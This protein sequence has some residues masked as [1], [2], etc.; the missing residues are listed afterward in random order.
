MP[1]IYIYRVYPNRSIQHLP[2]S[3]KKVQVRARCMDRIISP[4]GHTWHAF[5]LNGS[6]ASEEFMTYRVVPDLFNFR[7]LPSVTSSAV[8]ARCGVREASQTSSERGP[9][10]RTGANKAAARRPSPCGRSAQQPADVVT[11]RAQHRMQSV[12]LCTLQVTAVHPV[13]FLQVPDDRLDRLPPLEQLP[14]LR[15]E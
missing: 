5:L 2:I 8:A 15:C 14:F 6:Q 3:V 1:N 10:P 7:R 4:V 12:A 13:F 11:R 9:M